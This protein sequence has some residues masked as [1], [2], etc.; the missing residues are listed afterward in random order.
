MVVKRVLVILSLCLITLPTHA[1]MRND[2][3]EH[4]SHITQQD[5]LLFLPYTSQP[6]EWDKMFGYWVAGKDIENTLYIDNELLV[7][8]YDW[9]TLELK[10][11]VQFFDI[12]KL[13]AM[14]DHAIFMVRGS[15]PIIF[16]RQLDEN[17]KIFKQ[18]THYPT[19]EH[20]T[21]YKMGL[22]TIDKTDD[23]DIWMQNLGTILWIKTCVDETLNTQTD[24][25]N[26]P[27]DD[28]MTRYNSS[29][30][31]DEHTQNWDQSPLFFYRAPH[32]LHGLPWWMRMFDPLALPD[33]Q[34]QRIPSPAS[35]YYLREREY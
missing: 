32:S 18:I 31:A 8:Y 7:S 17:D 25:F 22:A 28:L 1:G 34:K 19:Q 24:L 2:G 26:L 27:N 5:N 9:T 35:P 4:E 21:F 13:Q 20:L 33:D 10:Q 12:K 16:K 3:G 6:F 11:G 30:C 15:E 29:Q 14:S 23:L